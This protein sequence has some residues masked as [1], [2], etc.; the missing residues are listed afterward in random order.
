MAKDQ[1]KSQAKDLL[2]VHNGDKKKAAERAKNFK[3]KG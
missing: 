3:A 2:R 1:I